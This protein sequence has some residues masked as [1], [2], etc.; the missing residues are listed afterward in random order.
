MYHMHPQVQLV[1]Q[2]FTDFMALETDHTK[3]LYSY[4][5]LR[6]EDLTGILLAFGLSWLTRGGTLYPDK[7][8]KKRVWKM[9]KN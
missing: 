4:L 6:K 1:W 3:Q 5:S 2:E 9:K 8:F 7:P